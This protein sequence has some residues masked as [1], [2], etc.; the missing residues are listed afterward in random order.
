[1]R[2]KRMPESHIPKDLGVFYDALAI[3][4]PD[5]TGNLYR[6]E[7][8]QRRVKRLLEWCRDLA[9]NRGVKNVLEMGCAE[10]YVTRRLSAIFEWVWAFDISAELIAR[11][12]SLHNVKFYQAD[13]RSVEICSP[14][15][16]T[17]SDDNAL[18]IMSEIL[19]HLRDPRE[20]L[21]RWAPAVR[22]LL[23]TCPVTELINK[24]AFDASLITR[25]TYPGDATGHIWAM[26]MAG[27][28]SLF[29]GL[30]CKIVKSVWLGHSGLALLERIPAV[31]AEAE[32]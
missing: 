3:G 12:P 8:A 1:M 10:G 18:V 20:L 29:K 17:E 11:C 27:F 24:N 7:Q 28:K 32:A 23:V 4:A 19:E 13:A 15:N 16:R 9:E 14:D 2:L 5:Y 30:P 25:E 22:Y 21:E 26:D 6:F 31:E